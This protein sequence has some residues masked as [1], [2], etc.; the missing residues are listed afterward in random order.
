M[1]YTRLLGWKAARGYDAI[2]EVYLTKKMMKTRMRGRL[3]QEL[4]VDGC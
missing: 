2:G 4:G 3:V 1:L